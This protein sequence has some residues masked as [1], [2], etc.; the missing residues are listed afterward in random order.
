MSHHQTQ[1]TSIALKDPGLVENS[2][3]A[4]HCVHACFQMVFRSRIGGGVPSFSELDSLL[5]KIPN[6][7]TWEHG[8]LA[9]M[10]ARGFDTRVVSAMSVLGLAND[11]H[12][13]IVDFYGDQVG[14]IYVRY[15][16]LSTVR[17]GAARLLAAKDVT[18]EERCPDRE[19]LVDFLRRGYY[20]ILTV[21]Q[22]TFQA[23]IGYA[24]HNVLVYGASARGPL[25][26]NPG[27]P[28]TAA[29]EIAWE[30]LDKAWSCPTARSRSI[31]AIRPQ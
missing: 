14:Q 19:D 25:I 24:A 8:L 6:R 9:E 26:H 27:P 21:N 2:E 17:Q 13:H 23:D 18:V 10:P 20:L 5:N 7:Y 31:I 12:R 15:S 30:L 28:A 22:R 4:Q 29:S 16:D 1:T 3:D 11:P